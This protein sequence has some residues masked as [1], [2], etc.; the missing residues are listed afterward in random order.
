M[1]NIYGIGSCKGTTADLLNSSSCVV[2]LLVVC[3]INVLKFF[4]PWEGKRSSSVA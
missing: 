1:P 4:F 3:F 2:I